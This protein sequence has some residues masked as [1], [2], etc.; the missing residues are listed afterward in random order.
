MSIRD[1]A[2]QLNLSIGTVSRALNDRPDVNAETRARVKAAAKRVGYQPDQSGRSL[3]KGSTGFVAA[4]LP[5]GP[6]SSSDGGLFRLLEATR[7]VLLREDI[8]LIVLLQGY[9]QNPLESLRRVVT[10]HIADAL[11]VSHTIPADPR[12]R[13][14]DE[15]GV[16]HV[17]LGRSEGISKGSYVDFDVETVAREVAERFA[18]EGHQRIALL[19]RDARM[20]FEELMARAFRRAAIDAGLA[21]ANVH[22]LDSEGSHMAQAGR[23]LVA[24]PE[25]RPTAILTTHESLAASLYRDLRPLGLEIG[26]DVAVISTSPTIDY[27]ALSPR[28]S[29]YETDLDAAGRAIGERLVAQI[30]G[31]PDAGSGTLL[32]P[33]QFRAMESHLVDTPR[34]L[35][36]INA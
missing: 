34:I 8:D 26:R 1:L 13:F 7:R 15:A 10:R 5:T 19:T 14:L 31:G 12:L 28:L 20:N 17:V 24:D 3:R 9:E 35:S 22:V 23:D 21:T 6:D 30:R 32:I 18:A 4:M 11:I 27:D 36:D 33:M 2:R 29:H 25:R 16:R